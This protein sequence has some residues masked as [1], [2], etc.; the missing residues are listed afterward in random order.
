MV[1]PNL[2]PHSQLPPLEDVL[3]GVK[4]ND[5]P[6]EYQKPKLSMQEVLEQL[7]D[8]FGQDELNKL[9]SEL[10]R[11][12]NLDKETTCPIL[13]GAQIT[14]RESV[15]DG[16]I[17]LLKNKDGTNEVVCRKYNLIESG[18]PLYSCCIGSGRYKTCP[19]HKSD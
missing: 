14:S 2:S 4:S 5:K 11:Y 7:K 9:V 13:R 16:I 15:Q 3:A 17:K 1:K 12:A 6:A 10:S 8:H 19:F 18:Y